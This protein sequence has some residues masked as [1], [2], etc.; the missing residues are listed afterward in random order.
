MLHTLVVADMSLSVDKELSLLFAVFYILDNL[1]IIIII[2]L[3]ID[4]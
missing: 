3:I 4:L 1:V 2:I